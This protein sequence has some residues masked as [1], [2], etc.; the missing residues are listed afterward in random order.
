MDIV[1]RVRNTPFL[2]LTA[3]LIA[4]I[5]VSR[6]TGEQYALW[7]FAGCVAT[8]IGALFYRKIT[9]YIPLFLFGLSLPFL[10][11]QDETIPRYRWLESKA[12]IEKQVPQGFIAEITEQNKIPVSRTVLLLSD[13]YLSSI[14][15][16]G[17][18]LRSA[19]LLEDLADSRVK[20]KKEYLYDGIT[21]YGRI[22][23]KGGFSINSGIRQENEGRTLYQLRRTLSGRFDSLNLPPEDI[24][25]VKGV[26]LGDKSDISYATK[27]KFRRSGVAHLLAISGWHIGIIFMFLNIVLFFMGRSPIL[28]RIRSV[29]IVCMIWFYAAISGFSPSV[30]RAALM[31]TLFQYLIFSEIPR[32]VKYNIIFATAFLILAYDRNYLWNIGFQLSFMAV[33]SIQIFYSRFTDWLP[34]MN[35]FLRFPIN[36]VAFTLSAQVLTFPIVLYYFGS[37]STVSLFSNIAVGAVM[38]VLM[39]ASLVYLIHPLFIAQWVLS[40]CFTV[41]NK[42]LDYFS[43]FEGGYFEKFYIN[44]FDLAAYFVFILILLILTDKKEI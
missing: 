44:G 41:L 39:I 30:C 40:T 14:L 4:A 12:V 36:A 24:S 20:D 21:E 8:T 29:M 25:I 15:H 3:V 11:R 1:K 2:Q 5:V 37:Y 43:S 10:Q 18:T 34:R 6:F 9:P 42:V 22:Q 13:K 23:V 17:D 28:K 16:P 35:N 32:G 31:F 7:A 38:P 26:V 27:E 19:L 33:L